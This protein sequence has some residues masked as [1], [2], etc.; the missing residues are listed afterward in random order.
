[1]LQNLKT[2]WLVFFSLFCVVV[3]AVLAPA[4]KAQFDRNRK[5]TTE[6]DMLRSQLYDYNKKNE[7]LREKV[8]FLSKLSGKEKL[9]REQFNLK[10]EGEIVVSF[11]DDRVVPVGVA[12]KPSTEIMPEISNFQSW[13]DYFFADDNF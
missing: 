12:A 10:K 13:L 7:E 9:A 11:N 5:I 3:L 1:M 6:I 2:S 8:E 4:V